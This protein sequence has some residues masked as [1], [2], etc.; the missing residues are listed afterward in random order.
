MLKG[1]KV[2][3]L[4][5]VLA[6][7]LC[8]MILG[9]MGADIIKVERPGEGDETPLFSAIDMSPP[10]SADAASIELKLG[11]DICSELEDLV[12]QLSL[13]PVVRIHHHAIRV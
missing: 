5:R 2:L 6:G 4:T 1:V 3:D 11:D 12:T 10:D 7:P 9:D 13:G 8:T